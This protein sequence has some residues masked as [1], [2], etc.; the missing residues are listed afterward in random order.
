MRRRELQTN[1]AAVV[2]SA[3]FRIGLGLLV[4]GI[5]LYLALTNLDYRD[6]GAALGQ[7]SPLYAGLA[8]A[9]VAVNT[10]SK[11]VRWKLLHGPTGQH[12]GL[13]RYLAVLLVGQMLNTLIPAR[14]GDL[15]RA[16]V[17]GGQGP[18]RVFVF[19]TIVIEKFLDTL[20]YLLLFFVLLLLLPLPDWVGLSAGRLLLLGGGSVGLVLLLLQRR[21]VVGLVRRATGWLPEYIRVRVARVV[22]SGLDS[23]D[24]LRQ[25]S[26]LVRLALLSALVWATA[27]L[28]NYLVLLAFDIDVPWIAALLVLVVLQAGISLPSIPGKFGVFEYSCILALGFFGVD[29]ALALSYGIVLHAIVLVPTTLIGLV[30]FWLM[31]IG[32]APPA[33][34][35]LA[36]EVQQVQQMQQQKL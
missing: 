24:V 16:Y 26:D 6:I 28:N 17:I 25:R 11:A 23:L 31:G 1:L 20:A 5:C 29:Q 30:C 2:S 34:T 10:V 27:V 12:I 32:A 15:S 3:P 4:S 7:A 22:Q 36:S 21:R 14:V 19:G 9:S 13:G 18:G 8:L 35:E 33:P